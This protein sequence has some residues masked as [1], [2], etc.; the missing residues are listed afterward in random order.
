MGRS[1]ARKTSGAP[2]DEIVGYVTRGRGVSVHSTDCP[3]V[4]NL[5]YHPEREIEVGWSRADGARY[6]V[7]LAIEADDQPGVLARLTEAITRLV[8]KYHDE[9]APGGRA[10]RLVI[11]AHPLPQESDPKEPS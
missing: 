10:H 3:N 5:L 11:L 1:T 2:G 9:S 4:R 6:E 7:A 8:A